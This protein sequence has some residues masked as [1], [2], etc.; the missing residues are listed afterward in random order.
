MAKPDGAAGS[1]SQGVTGLPLTPMLDERPPPGLARG[2]FPVPAWAVLTL[3][4]V[5]MLAVALYVY[6][7]FRHLVRR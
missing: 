7:Q 1:A 5:L 2:V 6:K 4:G 3:G